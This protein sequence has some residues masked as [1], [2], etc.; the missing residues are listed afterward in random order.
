MGPEHNSGPVSLWWNLDE[1]PL[2]SDSESEPH[3]AVHK[4]RDFLLAK[5]R[6]NK[7]YVYIFCHHSSF[8][9]VLSSLKSSENV[10]FTFKKGEKG[11]L[12]PVYTPSY[13][14]RLEKMI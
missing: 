12:L 3:A 2:P 9:D 8:S 1:F 6:E 11:N 10:V 5:G 7:A 4:L 13:S 14:V